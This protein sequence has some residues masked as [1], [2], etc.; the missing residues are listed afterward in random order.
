MEPLERVAV[1]ETTFKL[2]WIEDGLTSSDTP[3]VKSGLVTEPGET[4]GV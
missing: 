4:L 2:W 3:Y 1:G